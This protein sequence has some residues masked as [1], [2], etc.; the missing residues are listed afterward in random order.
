MGISLNVDE[1]F[2][3][4]YI[5]TWR[6]NI[7]EACH[8]VA[9]EMASSIVEAEQQSLSVPES[10][11]EWIPFALTL[12]GERIALE[13]DWMEPGR[14]DAD[15][16]ATLEE[17]DEPPE[18]QDM[19][20]QTNISPVLMVRIRLYDRLRFL[21]ERDELPPNE[22]QIEEIEAVLRWLRDRIVS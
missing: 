17:I 21:Q 19:L 22:K 10:S 16:L 2:A 5:N 3:H 9:T 11:D 14:F 18:Q 6:L 8:R 7:A 20:A 13:M 1:P 4:E 15:L 12:D